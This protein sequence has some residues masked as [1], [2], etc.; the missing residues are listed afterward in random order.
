LSKAERAKNVQGAF[1]VPI[2]AKTAV[3]GRRLIVVDDVQTSGATAEACTKAL[4]RAAALNVDVLVF[5]RVVDLARP[6]I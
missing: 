1:S 2:E 6:P 3:K 5:A 4:L